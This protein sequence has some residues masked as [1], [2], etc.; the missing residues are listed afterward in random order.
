MNNKDVLTEWFMK[1]DNLDREV[2]EQKAL[3]IIAQANKEV[4]GIAK[5]FESLDDEPTH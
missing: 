4:Q 1:K 5:A 3:E 2:A